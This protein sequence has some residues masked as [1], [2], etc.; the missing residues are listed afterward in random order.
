MDHAL[1]CISPID[2]RYAKGIG[3]LEAFTSERALI[4][5]RLLVECEWLLYLDEILK[6][7]VGL[8]FA[9]RDRIRALPGEL[10]DADFYKVKELEKETNHDV[11]ACEYFLRAFL[12][13][14]GVS[15]KAQSFIHFGLTSEDVNNLA[16]ALMVKEM[17]SQ[18]ILPQMEKIEAALLTLGQ[19]TANMAMSA[20]THGQPASPTT[21]GKE[22]AVFRHR[23]HSQK[24]LLSDLDIFGKL[25]G[26]VGCY[27]ALHIAYPK[28]DWPK[29]CQVFVEERL[30]LVFN[31]LT[32]QI[33]NHDWLVRF[34]Q[35]LALY[36]QIAIGLCQDI[37]QYIAK[38]YFVL[39]TVGHE[40][41]SS[42]MPHKVNPIDFEN[43]EGNFGLS[44]ALCGF[45]AAKLPISRLQ[46]DL[47][48][49]TVLRSVGTLVAHHVL[50]QR[51]LARG[52]GKIEANPAQMQAELTG[53]W[54]VL[55]EAVQTVMR[56]NG[57]EDAYERLKELS[58]GKALAAS[59]IQEFVKKQPIAEA[60]REVLLGLTP[61]SYLGLAEQL[62]GL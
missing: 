12:I 47:S 15:K 19:K 42:T 5:F 41:G 2:G 14:H 34:S 37:W 61:A 58:R 18:V 30:S 59:D 6:D 27:H 4:R 54:E 11:K 55:T 22:L 48:D 9:V 45:F 52:L 16:Y 44:S 20:F 60:D 51:A 23:L 39:K 40:V 32:T 31:P 13:G 38:K 28:T 10:G 53:S 43:A 25:N 46:R 36:N 7:Q 50:A 62:A 17:R 35:G 21:M 57:I 3:D 1:S 24:Q 33:E 29:V 8:P 49:S 26:A 56:K